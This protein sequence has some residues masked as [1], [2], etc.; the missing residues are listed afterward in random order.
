MHIVMRTSRDS[1]VMNLTTVPSVFA[2]VL[3][4]LSALETARWFEVSA[5]NQ[6]HSPQHIGSRVYCPQPVYVCF[7]FLFAVF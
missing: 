2:C 1:T 3:A 5:S 4:T 7:S 6:D